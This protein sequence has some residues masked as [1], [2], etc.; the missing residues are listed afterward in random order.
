MNSLGEWGGDSSGGK[1]GLEGI[2]PTKPNPPQQLIIFPIL[3]NY[4]GELFASKYSRHT[5]LLLVF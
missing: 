3:K 1:G 5:I 4:F 2:I